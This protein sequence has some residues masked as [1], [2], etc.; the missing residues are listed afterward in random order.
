[1]QYAFV[2]QE[3]AGLFNATFYG[4][5]CD[6]ASVDEAVTLGRQQISAT[7]ELLEQ[8]DWS[9]PVLYLGTRSVHLLGV[10]RNDPFRR[11]WELV[12]TAA[13]G[14]TSSEAA[15]RG[16]VQR[17]R[18]VG[19]RI[20]EIEATTRLHAAVH[21]AQTSWEPYDQLIDQ[22][23]RSGN[24]L[25]P[26]KIADIKRAWGSYRSTQWPDVQRHA[27]AFASEVVE[28]WFAPLTQAVAGVDGVL[29]FASGA[30]GSAGVVQRNLVPERAAALRN[31]LALAN[32]ELELAVGSASREAVTLFR[33]TLSRLTEGS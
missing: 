24:V 30:A 17:L 33:Q 26:D 8:R 21:T 2:D 11:D 9:T 28:P 22:T 3:T 15:V 12:R 1:M 14:S 10:S 18:D 19:K 25:A 20:N 27:A 29:G 32:H 6:G 23:D 4:A 13:E 5:L 16:L 31:A 7:G